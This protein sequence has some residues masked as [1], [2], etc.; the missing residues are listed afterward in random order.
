MDAGAVLDRHRQ[1]PVGIGVAQVLLHRE[2]ELGKVGQGP[3]VGVGGPP[4]GVEVDLSDVLDAFAEDYARHAAGSPYN[5]LYDRPAVLSLLADVRGQR[6]LDA[7]CG[8]GI[9]TH[10]LVTTQGVVGSGSAPVYKPVG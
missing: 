8:R 4:E 5:A 10:Y 1:H 9:S 2:G 7:A 6:V 3:E